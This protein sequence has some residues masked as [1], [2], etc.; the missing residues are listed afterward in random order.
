MELLSLQQYVNKMVIFACNVFVCVLQLQIVSHRNFNVLGV[1]SL[2]SLYIMSLIKYRPD[3]LK[4]AVG[5]LEQLPD[6][7]NNLNVFTHAM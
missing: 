6:F 4:Y 3:C 7:C 5:N 1:T 2:Q